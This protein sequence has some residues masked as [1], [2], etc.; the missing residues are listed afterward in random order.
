MAYEH[1]NVDVIAWAIV[2]ILATTA[3]R[4]FFR[5]HDTH[6]HHTLR[7]SLHNYRLVSVSPFNY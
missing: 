3:K 5:L 1:D 2:L 4:L 7:V 6:N